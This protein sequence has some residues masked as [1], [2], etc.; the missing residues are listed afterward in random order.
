LENQINREALLDTWTR[1]HCQSI[2][3]SGVTAGRPLLLVF[4]ADRAATAGS[5][6]DVRM[7][8]ADLKE[9]SGGEVL[10]VD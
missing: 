6:H 5:V 9:L 8:M 4:H 3:S 1:L 7:A 2:C 10:K